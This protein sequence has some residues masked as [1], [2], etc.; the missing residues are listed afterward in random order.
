MFVNIIIASF[1]LA[2]VIL[3]FFNAS[4]I[5]LFFFLRLILC[6]I[7]SAPLMQADIHFLAHKILFYLS[8]GSS[9]SLSTLD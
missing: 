8:T 4:F 1:F 9:K 5:P 6:D 3:F 7:F 2:S